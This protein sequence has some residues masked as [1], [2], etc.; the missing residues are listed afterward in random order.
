MQWLPKVLFKS[1]RPLFFNLGYY[2]SIIKE[3]IS[4]YNFRIDK[5]T[6]EREYNKIYKSLSRKYEG[7]ELE[8]KI[9]QKLYL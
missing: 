3:E 5:G 6:Y 8:Y 1:G 2:T 7:N 4:T 9:K